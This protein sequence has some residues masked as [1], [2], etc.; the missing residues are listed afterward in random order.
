MYVLPAWTQSLSPQ[1]RHSRSP[2]AFRPTRRGRLYPRARGDRHNHLVRRDRPAHL[3]ADDHGHPPGDSAEGQQ[4]VA[5][6]EAMEDKLP[7]LTVCVDQR[8]RSRPARAAFREANVSAHDAVDVVGSH[9]RKVTDVRAVSATADRRVARV[10]ADE[11]QNRPVRIAL[12]NRVPESRR[13]G[14]TVALLEC[15]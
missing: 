6:A 1:A 15:L 9:M 14:V 5:V 2:A 13:E 10:P 12:L 7:T 3:A 11:P 4:I 8:M